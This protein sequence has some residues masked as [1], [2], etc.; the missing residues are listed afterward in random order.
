[1]TALAS[2]TEWPLFRYRVRDLVRRAPVTCDADL[3]IGQAASVMAAS[4]VGSI[5][6]VDARGAPVGIVTLRDVRTRVL[7]ASR[8]TD[9]P[10]AEV[11]SAPLVAVPADAP[12][13]DALLGMTRGNFHHVG[14][15]E[16]GRLVGVLGRD[17]LP[18]VASPDPIAMARAIEEAPSIEALAGAAAMQVGVLRALVSEGAGAV[19]AAAVVAELSD[20]L[21][22]R[23]TALALARLSA[24]GLGRPPVPWSFVAA[25]SE[26]R[27]EQTLKTDQDS[28][29]VYADPPEDLEA[30]A[31]AYFARL[32][33]AI[34][35]G[36]AQVG[37]PRCEGGYMAENPRWC[38]PL[39]VWRRRVA[40]WFEEPEPVHLL[41]ASVYL[42]MRPVAGDDG[43]GRELATWACGEAPR[44]PVFLRLLARSATERRP[45]IGL[46]GR[47]RTAWTGTHRGTIDL[48]GSGV[49]PVT[50]AMRV[51]ALAFGLTATGTL[52]RLAGAAARGAFTPAEAADLEAAYRVILR[53]RLDH[54]LAAV[55]A[56][57]PPDNRVAPR[58]LGRID[59]AALTE[60]FRT[61]A[62][63][64]RAVAER[65]LVTQ[66]G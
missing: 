27:R 19:E 24:D 35:D 9:T 48:K 28:G 51:Y 53:V 11:M 25:G 52:D 39:A 36:L 5:V 29:L 56:G 57:R 34:G 66:A 47:L 42:D 58:R 23:V 46:L 65:F 60:A 33:R 49:F 32:A 59:R 31:A 64:Q 16:A 43:P 45:P 4:G 10:V 14:V 21:V 41:E 61:V 54:Q 2:H 6:V 50:Q 38:Q 17:D 3:P 15:I 40:S 22:R 44:Y 37:V 8:S 13:F 30:E 26:G 20:R 63:L 62:S 1:M 7:A 12:A 18:S 55:A